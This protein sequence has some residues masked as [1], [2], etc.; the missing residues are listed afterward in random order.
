MKINFISAND[1]NT[2]SG[3]AKRPPSK[4]LQIKYPEP[5]ADGYNT[6]IALKE[7]FGREAAANILSSSEIIQIAH[8]SYS[9]RKD[10]MKFVNGFQDAFDTYDGC[11]EQ[12]DTDCD[13]DNKAPYITVQEDIDCSSKENSDKKDGIITKAIDF[14]KRVKTLFFKNS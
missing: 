7:E 14:L 1:I 2:F 6:G 11:D 9:S 12:K 3:K 5:Y 13:F 10:C 8:E 4:M